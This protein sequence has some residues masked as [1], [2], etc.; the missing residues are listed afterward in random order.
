MTEMKTE[1]RCL[2]S[3]RRIDIWAVVHKSSFDDKTD[4]DIR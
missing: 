3:N 1:Q 4:D 2:S